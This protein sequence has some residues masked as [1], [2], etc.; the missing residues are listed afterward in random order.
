MCNFVCVGVLTLDVSLM[1]YIAF[2]W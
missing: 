1:L 2:A